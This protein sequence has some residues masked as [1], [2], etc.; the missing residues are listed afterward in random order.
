MAAGG[1][2]LERALGGLLAL[3]V[4]ELGIVRRVLDQARRGRREHLMA[5]EVVDQ[6]EQRRG[7]EDLD[8]AAEPGRLAAARRGA[9]QAEVARRRGDRGRQHARD[10]QH[11]AI[12]REL[13]ERQVAL[14]R[15]RRHGAHADQQAERDRQVEMAA[16]LGEIGRREVD[17]DALGRQ[18]EAH[19]AERAPDPLAR[20][21]DRLVGQPDHGERR[22]PGAIWTWTSTSLTSMPENAT[23]RSRATPSE[24]RLTVFIAKVE[25]HQRHDR[26][27]TAA[28]LA[29]R[30]HAVKVF[31]FWV[32]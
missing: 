6:R 22:Q 2:D 12:E 20:F 28:I 24:G 14:H 26:A 8:V 29:W 7:R 30:C 31:L 25:P 5:A 1:G 3:D 19:R 18:A 10:R 27:A 16:L 13:A 4:G 9:D 23:V 32:E 15:I 17:R 11:R 21:G